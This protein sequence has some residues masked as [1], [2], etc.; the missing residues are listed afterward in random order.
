MRTRTR[1]IFI[2]AAAVHYNEDPK[3]NWPTTAFG[4]SDDPKTTLEFPAHYKLYVLSAKDRGGAW[5]HGETR[6]AAV[7]TTTNEVIYWADSW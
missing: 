5:N 4:T 2:C 6:G 7:S 1:I 3:N